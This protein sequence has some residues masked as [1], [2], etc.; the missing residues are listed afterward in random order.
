VAQG[1]PVRPARCSRAVAGDF[2][3]ITFDIPADVYAELRGEAAETG[4]SVEGLAL[5]Y[6]RA[7]MLQQQAEQKEAAELAQAE[8]QLFDQVRQQ[9]AQQAK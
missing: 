3:L 8:R 5:Y 1:S 9:Q 2:M 4:L 7:G 6:L